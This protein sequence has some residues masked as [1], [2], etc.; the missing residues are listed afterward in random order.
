MWLSEA[1]A[2]D[3]PLAPRPEGLMVDSMLFHF[4][5]GWLLWTCHRSH[6]SRI[7]R[8]LLI[9]DNFAFGQRVF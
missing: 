5:F 4:V 6:G 3:T 9:N 7:F 2:H 1:S 8:I